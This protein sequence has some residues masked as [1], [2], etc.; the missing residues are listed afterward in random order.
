MGKARK[1]RKA[2]KVGKAGKGLDET[3]RLGLEG[4]YH[5]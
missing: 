1:V 2:R 3:G 5:P 4:R